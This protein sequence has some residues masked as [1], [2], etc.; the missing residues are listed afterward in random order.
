MGFYNSSYYVSAR[1]LQSLA[2]LM[3]PRLAK[4]LPLVSA[5]HSVKAL[6]TWP[7]E[8]LSRCKLYRL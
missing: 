8:F 4:S 6:R 1:E 3:A 2:L 5:F 7:G